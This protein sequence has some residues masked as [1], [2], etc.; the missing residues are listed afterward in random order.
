MFE[1]ENTYLSF[2]VDESIGL[3]YSTWLRRVSSEEY[4]EGNSILV[5]QLHEKQ[6]KHW[7]ADSSDLG[8]ISAEDQAWT[9]QQF[10]PLLPQTS[11]VKL[12]RLSGEDTASHAKFEQFVKRAEP[13]YIGDIQVKQFMSYKEAADWVGDVAV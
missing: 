2:W 3:M 12:A 11:L 10:I 9:L 1:F 5:Q 6:V 7:I 13:I 8:D 4:R